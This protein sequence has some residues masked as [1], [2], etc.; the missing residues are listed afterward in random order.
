MDRKTIERI[1]AL[2]DAHRSSLRGCVLGEGV[3]QLPAPTVA[4]LLSKVA[5]IKPWDAGNDPYHEHDFG[6]IE[7][8]GERLFWRIDYYDAD[9]QFHSPDPSDPSVTRRVLTITRAE[10]Y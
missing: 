10:D 7:V 2:N 4:A 9:L 6:C 8:D 3:A 5:E 1:A